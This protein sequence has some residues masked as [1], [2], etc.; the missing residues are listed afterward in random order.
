M[1]RVFLLLKKFKIDYIT[2]QVKVIRILKIK[3][4]S[5]ITDLYIDDAK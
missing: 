5:I 2:K 1:I 4:Y 3:M